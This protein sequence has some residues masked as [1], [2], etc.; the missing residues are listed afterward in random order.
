MSIGSG[1][2]PQFFVAG[3]PAMALRVCLE[4]AARSRDR[5]NPDEFRAQANHNASLCVSASLRAILR[6]QADLKTDARLMFSAT[7]FCRAVASGT[8]ALRGPSN[9]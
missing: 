6:V 9:L 3:A 4:F 2:V 8:F 7:E 5:K 1:A